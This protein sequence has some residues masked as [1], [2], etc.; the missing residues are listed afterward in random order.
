MNKLFECA[1]PKKPKHKTKTYKK[2]GKLAA[3]VW[4]GIWTQ[5]IGWRSRTRSMERP[6]SRRTIGINV[7]IFG[8]V[9]WNLW[10]KSE[11][12]GIEASNR[13]NRFEQKMSKGLFVGCPKIEV[14]KATWLWRFKNL[15]VTLMFRHLLDFRRRVLTVLRPLFSR[16]MGNIDFASTLPTSQVSLS[17]NGGS[18]FL[19]LQV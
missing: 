19:K 12:L 10:L 1:N 7:R 11:Q 5:R 13:G 8:K 2:G 3:F 17:L 18:S 15:F 4:S 16:H 9:V 6:D 14:T